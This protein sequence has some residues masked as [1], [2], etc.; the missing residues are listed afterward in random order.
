MMTN[1]KYLLFSLCGSVDVLESV[2]LDIG[3]LPSI[4]IKWGCSGSNVDN[5]KA[6]M[7]Y[8]HNA[9]DALHT[10]ISVKV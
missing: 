7:L 5:K 8:G 10:C 1:Y 2:T 4:F 6:L 3:P 9:H